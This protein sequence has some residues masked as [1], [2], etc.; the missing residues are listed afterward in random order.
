MWRNL[1]SDLA[2]KSDVCKAMARRAEAKSLPQLEICKPTSGWY[3]LVF[4]GQICDE[5]WSLLFYGAA[6]FRAAPRAV[7]RKHEPR[8]LPGGSSVFSE[9]P[10]LNDAS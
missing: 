6:G 7:S 3:T 8:C 1:Y 5:V 10:K 4:A 9:N 2:E